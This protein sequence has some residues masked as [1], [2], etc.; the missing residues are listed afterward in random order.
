[1]TQTPWVYSRGR[2]WP[3][4]GQ[5]GPVG[6]AKLAYAPVV[7]IT[8]L[9]ATE[10]LGRDTF[11]EIDQHI[12]FQQVTNAPSACARNASPSSSSKRSEPPTPAPGPVVVNI[13]RDLF[14]HEIDVAPRAGRPVGSGGERAMVATLG[15]IKALLLAARALVIHAGAGI[16]WGRGTVN[17]LQ[18]AEGLQLPITTSAGHGDV[19]PVQI[20]PYTLVALAH[21]ATRWRAG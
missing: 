1:M 2:A 16:K 17:L 13:P 11:Q 5:Y 19:A 15:H 14:N 20:I 8:G 4:R 21:A 7:V 12:L 6:P 18:L 9:P 3:G 10:H